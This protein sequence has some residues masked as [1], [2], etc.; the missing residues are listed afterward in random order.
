MGSM[1]RRAPLALLSLALIAAGG[2]VGGAG[3]AAGAKKCKPGVHGFD[4]STKARTF[5]GPATAKVELA[6][7]SLISY[8]RGSCKK[9]TKYV[10]VNIGTTVLGQ[11]TKKKPEYFG[12]TVGRTAAGGKPAP[13]DGTYDGAT[14]S[15]VHKNKT[16]ALGQSSVVLTNNRT[17]GAFAGTIPGQQGQIVGSFRCK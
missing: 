4:G 17:R 6:P 8:R 16:Y 14:I 2:V 11:T 9:T 3:P 10:T 5:C 15:F 7:G 13:E 1:R 12:L